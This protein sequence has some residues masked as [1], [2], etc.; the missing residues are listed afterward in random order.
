[1]SDQQGKSMCIKITKPEHQKLRKLLKTFPERR[2]GLAF[3]VGWFYEWLKE[4]DNRA[5][6]VRV[7]SKCPKGQVSVD[8]GLH[9]FINSIGTIH[10][11]PIQCVFETACATYR[12]HHP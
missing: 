5:T 9:T 1:M 8:K 2:I 6:W 10:N 11:Q 3:I 4:D 7:P 12:R